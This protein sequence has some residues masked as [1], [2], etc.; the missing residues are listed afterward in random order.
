MKKSIGALVMAVLMVCF[1]FAGCQTTVQSE[2]ETSST[3]ETEADVKESEP[4]ELESGEVQD[5]NDYTIGLFVKDATTPFW[6]YVVQGAQEEADA[7]GVKMVEYAPME[8]TDT[9]EQIKQVEDAIQAGVDAICI[10]AIDS[11][12]IMPALESAIEADIPVITFNS[13]VSMDG[14]ETFVGVDNYNGSYKVTERMFADMNYEGNLVIIESDPAAYV[15]IERVRA[16]TDLVEKYP[17]VNVLTTQPAYARREQAMSVMENILQTYDEID[18]VWC[19]NDATALGVVQAIQ[20]AGRTDI[21][22][23]GFDGTP[24]G[25]QAVLDGRL[26]YTLDQSPFEQGG[27][28]IRAAVDFL[29]GEEI[30]EEIATGGTVVDKENGQTLLDQYE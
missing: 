18:M 22:V 24:E 25:I 16:V 6:R 30:E 27:F 7:L 13:R 9:E 12:A 5:S 3:S 4:E 20:G 8:N 26:A 17:D 15:N 19:L 11:N 29:N 14:I 10:V 1:V 28:S 23:S 21:L 2:D